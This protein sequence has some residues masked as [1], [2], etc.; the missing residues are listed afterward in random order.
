[1]M[2]ANTTTANAYNKNPAEHKSDRGIKKIGY[3][4]ASGLTRLDGKLE[5]LVNGLN[6]LVRRRM[7]NNDD[8]SNQANSA[9]ETP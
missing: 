3:L 5:V 1:M 9:T 2:R 4:V 8:S 6:L 7:E